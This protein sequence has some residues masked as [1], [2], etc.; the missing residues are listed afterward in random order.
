[1]SK[2]RKKWIDEHLGKMD[3]D[4][5]VGQMMVFGLCGTVSTPDTVEMIR[6]YHVGGIRIG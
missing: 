5:K 4:Q 2:A 6:K 1:M 3:L